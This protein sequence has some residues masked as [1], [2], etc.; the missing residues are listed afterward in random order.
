MFEGHD[1]TAASINWTLYLLGRHPEIQKKV[2]EEID[3]VLG[4]NPVKGKISSGDLSKMKYLESCIKESLR[5][6]PSVPFIGRKLAT[7]LT[8][9]EISVV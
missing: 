2:H 3:S 9:G 4:G 7:D 5:I 1:T 6:Y 8:L